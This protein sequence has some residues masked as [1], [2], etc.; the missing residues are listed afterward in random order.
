MEDGLN[1]N[2]LESSELNQKDLQDLGLLPAEDGSMT[3][4]Q[5]SE[6]PSQKTEKN[7]D[8]P[9]DQQNEPSTSSE[10]I[11]ES[12]LNPES[13]ANIEEDKTNDNTPPK[14]T[15][16]H[17]NIFQLAKALKEEGVLSAVTEEDLKEIKS[18]ADLVEAINKEVDSKL[19]STTKRVKEALTNGI[20]PSKVQTYENAINYLD[21][22]EE[23]TLNSDADESIKLR[24]QLIYQDFINRGFNKERAL[25][26][27]KKS[28]DAGTDI[29]DAVEALNSNKT[30]FQNKYNNEINEARNQ[31]ETIKQQYTKQAEELKK[32]IIEDDSLYKDFNVN[33]NV[34]EKIFN[35]MLAPKYVDENTG[36]KLTEFTKYIRDNKE[37][38]IKKIGLL[39]T[40]TDGFKNINK[41]TQYNINKAKTKAIADL[42]KTL[43]INPI[44][45]MENLHYTS[46]VNG[47]TEAAPTYELA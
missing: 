7:S 45:G 20:E 29:E 26:E 44:T 37:D 33:K 3:P 22:I 24:Q 31:N 40:L 9:V 36:E 34:R 25:K 42:E 11:V 28:M 23:E 46:G 18:A 43:T 10:E 19:D 6:E 15:V 35:N 1:I 8:K 14:G 2:M 16:N 27:V 39:F 17:S 32:S 30:F 47:I 38:Y 12:L 5:E 13:V 41:L 4:A 21:S